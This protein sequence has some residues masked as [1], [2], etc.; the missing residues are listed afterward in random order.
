[1]FSDTAIQSPSR[2]LILRS[3]SF[4][5]D[6]SAKMNSSAT[7]NE[8]L[9]EEHL[10]ERYGLWVHPH[11]RQYGDVIDSADDLVFTCIGVYITVMC[12]IGAF[13]SCSVIFITVT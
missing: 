10:L 6:K 5:C 8:T 4:G 2:R 1:M 12:V 3:Y 9:L 7:K 11:W 13:A